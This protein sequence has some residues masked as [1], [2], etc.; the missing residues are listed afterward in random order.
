MVHHDP[1]LDGT[2]D[3]SGAIVEMSEA[4]VRK[5]VINYS[6][7]EHP[8]SLPELCTI[9]GDSQV[10]FRCE[11]KPDGDGFAYP[12]FVPKVIETL[13]SQNMLQRT[14]FSSFLMASLDELAV[15]T[16][17]PRLWLVSP[18]VL[19]QLGQAALIELCRSHEVPEIGVHVDSADAAL[20]AQ[21]QDAGLEF[22][23]WAAHDASQLNKAFE[24]GVK[25]LTC[26]RPSLAIELRRRF[27]ADKQEDE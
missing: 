26:D 6:G 22:G 27:A 2:T 17:R 3:R 18:A 10:D 8:L 20:M 9:Y 15:A 14:V 23:V 1:T 25:V 16:E 5:A 11:I 13:R 19:R 24:L 4:E 12:D 21:V 7:G